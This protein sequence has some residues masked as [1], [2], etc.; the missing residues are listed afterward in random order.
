[1]KKIKFLVVDDERPIAKAIQRAIESLGHQADVAFSG[2]EA[3]DF[4]DGSSYQV[5]LVDLIMPDFTGDQVIDIAKQN[6]HELTTAIMT[7]YRDEK[8]RDFVESKNVDKIFNKPFKNVFDLVSQ[9]IQIHEE[10]ERNSFQNKA[11]DLAIS[12]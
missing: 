9:L 4:L 6:G 7:A 12:K 8:T 1:M 3:I 10:L 2:Q 5:L 11:A